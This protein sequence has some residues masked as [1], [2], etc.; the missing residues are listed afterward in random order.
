MAEVNVENMEENAALFVEKMGFGHDADGLDMTDD[1]LVN[2][3][4]LCHQTTMGVDGEDA[5]YEDVD[6]E[7]MDL[8]EDVK[9]K[10]MKLDGG[11]VQDMMN[12][13]LGGH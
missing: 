13:L 1:Q 4:L 6:E 5:M 10:V 12:K 2:F 7:M 9:V 3:L 11:N 8:G